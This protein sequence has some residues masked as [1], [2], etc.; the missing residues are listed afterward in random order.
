MSKINIADFYYGAVLSS[1]APNTR[2]PFYI[3]KI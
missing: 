1:I 2:F 3:E